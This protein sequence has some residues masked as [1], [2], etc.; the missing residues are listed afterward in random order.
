MRSGL[1]LNAHQ[2]DLLAAAL[3][4]TEPDSVQIWTEIDNLL[5][6]QL[7]EVNSITDKLLIAHAFRLATFRFKGHF[8]SFKVTRRV[9][10]QL[11][12]ALQAKDPLL[13]D[14][15]SEELIV[16]AIDEK[17][18]FHSLSLERLSLC[19][20]ILASQPGNEYLKAIHQDIIDYTSY[21]LHTITKP[22]KLLTLKSVWENLSTLNISHSYLVKKKLYELI[23]ISIEHDSLQLCNREETVLSLL[24]SMVNLNF[25]HKL[26][27][28]LIFEHF[29]YVG[30]HSYQHW[31]KIFNFLLEL[32]TFHCI[33][34]CLLSSS[35]N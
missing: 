16:N 15:P 5:T 11:I 32:S 2:L 31:V 8:S 30:M 34:S 14:I 24:Q 18:T 6:P 12:Q 28:D 33:I 9:R 21:T 3:L 22:I 27:I 7:E 1:H 20:S 25:K 29:N 26:V 4:V 19:L 17:V 23:Q 13:F 10:E 35:D